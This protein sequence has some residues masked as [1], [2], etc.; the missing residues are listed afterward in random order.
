MW[1]KLK[2]FWRDDA[3]IGTREDIYLAIGITIIMFS[4]YIPYL[5][6]R[7]LKLF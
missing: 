1:E 5:L 6:W 2:E 4:P 7:L 3:D